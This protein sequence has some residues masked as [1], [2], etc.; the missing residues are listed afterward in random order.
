MLKDV[1]VPDIESR[2]VKEGFNTGDLPGVGNDGILQPGLPTLWRPRRTT[3]GGLS[4]NDL[5]L[6]L[7]DVNRVS[8]LREV[9][10]FPDLRRTE[11]GLFGNRPIPAQ[12]ERNACVVKDA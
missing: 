6:Y 2:Q 4:V 7:V 11:R 10:D 12:A 3:L 5:K 9:M 8:I 1:A